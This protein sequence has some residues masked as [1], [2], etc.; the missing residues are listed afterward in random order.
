MRVRTSG[1]ISGLLRSARDTVECDTPAARAISSIDTERCT[2]TRFLRENRLLLD[3]ADCTGLLQND[4]WGRPHVF[5]V[6]N[7]LGRGYAHVCIRRVYSNRPALSIGSPE[8]F[9]IK[10]RR[11][12]R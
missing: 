9:A 3:C 12:P 5:V 1:L 2:K 4:G 7:G 8:Y 11:Q 6:A 10:L